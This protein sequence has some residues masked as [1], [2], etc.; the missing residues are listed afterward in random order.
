MLNVHSYNKIIYKT[1][2]EVNTLNKGG[3]NCI[4]NKTHTGLDLQENAWAGGF[5]NLSHKPKE[6]ELS[7]PFD[8]ERSSQDSGAKDNH[9]IQ[10][11]QN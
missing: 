3:S 6:H 11:N 10:C 7:L 4:T 1:D 8:N 9:K 5:S 2:L